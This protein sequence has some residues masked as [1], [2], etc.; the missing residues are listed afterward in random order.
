MLYHLWWC[1]TAVL[2]GKKGSMWRAFFCKSVHRFASL[3]VWNLFALFYMLQ[4][5]QYRINLVDQNWCALYILASVWHYCEQNVPYNIFENR[6]P[7]TW[8]F[9][10]EF[11]FLRRLKFSLAEPEILLPKLVFLLK[12]S[13][14][15]SLLT[16]EYLEIAFIINNF[17]STVCSILFLW[18]NWPYNGTK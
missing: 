3:Q 15:P 2:F 12:D 18:R 6:C 4:S 16:N 11:Q 17:S 5:S 10:D 7:R 9:V 1:V 8:L 14:M 13:A